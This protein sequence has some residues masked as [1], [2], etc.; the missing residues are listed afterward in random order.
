MPRAHGRVHGRAVT[1]S[2]LP[3][4]FV[5]LRG[6]EELPVCLPVSCLTEGQTVDDVTSQVG[7]DEAA[8]SPRNSD[9]VSNH[10]GGGGQR[11]KPLKKDQECLFNLVLI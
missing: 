4:A 8:V 6:D 3:E 11:S 7:S 9:R 1:R 5:Q 2:H 10:A